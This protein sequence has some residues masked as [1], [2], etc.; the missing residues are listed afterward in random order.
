MQQPTTD[1]KSD[2]VQ[3][4]YE[5]ASKLAEDHIASLLDSATPLTGKLHTHL[6]TVGATMSAFEPT[7]PLHQQM[8][9]PTFKSTLHAAEVNPLRSTAESTSRSQR[10]K[11]K[12]RC[13]EGMYTVTKSFNASN[14]Q[15]TLSLHPHTRIAIRYSTCPDQGCFCQPPR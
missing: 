10:R 4:H 8:D 9:T 14:S 6:A 12:D 2:L 3:S 13:P 15:H 11:N 5:S 1:L 7:L